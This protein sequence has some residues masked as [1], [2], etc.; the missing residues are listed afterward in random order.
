VLS[1]MLAN[2]IKSL[3]SATGDGEPLPVLPNPQGAR[4]HYFDFRQIDE[5]DSFA[6]Y[7][8]EISYGQVNVSGD[9]YGWADVPW[10]VLPLGDFEVDE[11]ATSIG[12]LV[13]PFADLNNNGRYDEF[14]PFGD[15]TP[16]EFNDVYSTI[17]W[18]S[19]FASTPGY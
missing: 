12:G 16:S 10:P 11:D 3:R 1:A 13:L 17:S 5:I 15:G 9:V 14:M 2:P 4:N 6:E 8:H 19:R 7:W 18:G